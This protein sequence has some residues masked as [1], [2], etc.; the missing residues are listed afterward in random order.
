MR[1]KMPF[2]EVMFR[3]VCKQTLFVVILRD[4]SHILAELSE[5]GYITPDA[6]LV[7]HFVHIF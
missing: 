2:T 3:P 4:G 1:D 7:R 6:D 5:F